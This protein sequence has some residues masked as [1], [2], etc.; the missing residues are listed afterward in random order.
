MPIEQQKAAPTAQ[1]ENPPIS[2]DRLRMVARVAKSL[3]DA[4]FDC[5]GCCPFAHPL[6]SPDVLTQQNRRATTGAGALFLARCNAL[7]CPLMFG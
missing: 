2:D 3:R 7:R 4:G 5:D 1:K 6:K